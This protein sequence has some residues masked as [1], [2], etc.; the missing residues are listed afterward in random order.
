LKSSDESDFLLGSDESLQFRR[1]P[2]DD[3]LMQEG[4][5]ESLLKAAAEWKPGMAVPEKLLRYR[6][7]Q[8]GCLVFVTDTEPLIEK[9]DNYPLILEM[10]AH[11]LT[12]EEVSALAF[13][14]GIHLRGLNAFYM[15][16][17]QAL[18]NNR[19]QIPAGRYDRFSLRLL[20]KQAAI[21]TMV[22]DYSKI[23]VG[24]A[25]D[26]L[27][28]VEA[29]L[30]N[31]VAWEGLSEKYVNAYPRYEASCDCECPLN[32]WDYGKSIVRESAM[33]NPKL[34]PTYLSVSHLRSILNS[35]E[36]RIL[37]ARNSD[38][39]DLMLLQILEIYDPDHR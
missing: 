27:R 29:D 36:P 12:D 38:K 25:E 24:E 11:S 39:N 23:G 15:D 4:A 17:R 22:L 31:G 21:R 28:K 20:E 32:L 14:R 16:V 18:R 37:L 2:W 1:T 8:M 33:T 3:D 35:R 10:V 19:A 34:R 5:Y 13:E 26:I 7:T 30:M 9:L 6:N